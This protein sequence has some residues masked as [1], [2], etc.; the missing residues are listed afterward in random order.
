MRLIDAD[1]AIKRID[2]LCEKYKSDIR[3]NALLKH[4][5]I[6]IK[7]CPTVDPCSDDVLDKIKAD[8]REELSRNNHSWYKAGMEYCLEIIDKYKAGM[9]TNE[10]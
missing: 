4:T 7:R 9:G 8:I 2:A 5:S 3:D 6:F 10:H 1:E